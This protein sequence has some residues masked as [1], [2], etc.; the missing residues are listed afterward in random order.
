MPSRDAQARLI[1][2]F[3][4]WRTPLRRFLVLRWSVRPA[5]LD[6]VSQ[7]VFLRLLR[8]DR[9]E[10]VEHP[11]AYLF[12]MASNV[13]AERAMRAAHRHPHDS[14]WLAE[15]RVESEHEPQQEVERAAAHAHLQ[16]VL[17]KLPP[18]SRE[19]L[20]LHFGENL[21]HAQIAEQLHVTPRIVKRDL[22]NAYARLRGELDADMVDGL[23]IG[24]AHGNTR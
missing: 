11:Q 2:W 7:E 9:A 10:L 8:Y 12:R 19:V 5:D 17:E 20:R 6:D 23:R 16:G 1:D 21:S 13:A 18:R 22:I 15:L 4:H 14:S 3:R 24:E